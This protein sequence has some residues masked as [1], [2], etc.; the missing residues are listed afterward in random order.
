MSYNIHIITK[1]ARNMEATQKQQDDA[2]RDL[3]V[4]MLKNIDVFKRLKD[5]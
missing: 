5:R 3:K 2:L 1:R 4:I